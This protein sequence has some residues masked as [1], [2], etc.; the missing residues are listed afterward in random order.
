M[1][2]LK[3]VV[4]RCPLTL[5]AAYRSETVP[6]LIGDFLITS[7]GGEDKYLKKIHR[8]GPNF[9]IGWT[10]HLV[11]AKMVINELYAE[12]KDRRVTKRD[13]E[14][15]LSKHDPSDFGS[16]QV[17]LI[18]WIIDDEQYCFRWNS[19]WSQEL[20][21]CPYC[22]DGSGGPVLEELIGK[23]ISA[24]GDIT[25]QTIHAAIMD[26]LY[27]AC[28]LTS[29]EV[30][31]KINREMHFGFAYEIL[32]FDGTRFEYVDDILYAFVFV[33]LDPT[34]T[35]VQREFSPILYRY[36]NYGE[37]SIV[38]VFD[39]TDRFTRH[40]I[41]DSAKQ[42]S[43]KTRYEIGKMRTN[44]QK[45]KIRVFELKSVYYC[46]YADLIQEGKRFAQVPL[47]V[48]GTAL[49]DSPFISIT[50]G[51]DGSELSIKEAVFTWAYNSIKKRRLGHAKEAAEDSLSN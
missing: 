30:M 3:S 31:L 2:K 9:A 36:N 19:S 48:D 42:R 32:Y 44:W 5:V 10:G 11:V 51:K 43:E 6:I 46:I 24:P 33:V 34:G 14:I 37:Y 4:W 12:F 35:I 7:E 26:V 17:F 22:Y 49:E 40:Y 18:G 21:L 50:D 41:I 13:I 28:I 29:D 25:P 38:R 45:G 47:I 8:I 15:H 27:T 16:L 20:F 23:R 39:A 1:W